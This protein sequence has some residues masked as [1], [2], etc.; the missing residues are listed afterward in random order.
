MTDRIAKLPS[1]L[2]EGLGVG[3]PSFRAAKSPHPAAT[4]QHAAKSRYPS[5]TREGMRLRFLSSQFG[6]NQ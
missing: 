4:R 2:R 1:R 3:L 6:L 5:R